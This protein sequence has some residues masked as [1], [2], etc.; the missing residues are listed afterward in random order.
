MD[1]SIFL[2][3]QLVGFVFNVV[4]YWK[5]F[6]KAGIAGWKALIPIYNVVVAF[7]MVGMSPW[8]LLLMFIPL[9]NLWIAI[10]FISNLADAFGK[11]FGFKVGLILLAPIFF[12]ILAFGNAE[13]QYEPEA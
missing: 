12:L 5:I 7:K 6:E 4:C 3:I 11:G 13:Y 9:V 8:T 10:S 1:D 2:L